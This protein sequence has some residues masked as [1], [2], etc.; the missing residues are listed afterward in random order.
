M[1]QVEHETN[2]VKGSVITA[3]N[4]DCNY[5]VPQLFCCVLLSFLCCKREN[6]G[7]KRAG[8]NERT[9]HVA[10]SNREWEIR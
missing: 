9:P 7:V 2:E 4:R 10:R 5:I 6:R 1:I 3:N 8:D